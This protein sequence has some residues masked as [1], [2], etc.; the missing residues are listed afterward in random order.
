MKQDYRGVA[1][2]CFR[3]ITNTPAPFVPQTCEA[4]NARQFWLSG[5]ETPN[6]SKN[7]SG[8][9]FSWEYV[10]TSAIWDGLL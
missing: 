7:G 5:I 6:P 9:S 10:A 4:E 3:S 2:L 1:G 8:V